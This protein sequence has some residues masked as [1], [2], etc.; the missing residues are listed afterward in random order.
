MIYKN[1]EFYNVEEIFE[2]P[3]GLQLS[4]IPES[5]RV[6]LNENAKTRALMPA[7]CEL[8]FNLKSEKAKIVMKASNE[9]IP[10]SGICE[11]YFGDFFEKWSYISENPTLIEIQYPQ[12][13]EKLREIKKE[14]NLKFDPQVIRILLPH[15]VDL[16]ILE[17]DGEFE[18]PEK[19]QVPDKKFLAYGSSITHGGFSIV[20]S[21]TYVAKTAYI[22]GI[23][24][25]NLGFG[26]GAHLEKEIADYIA[27]RKDWDFATF[28][29]GINMV[30]S[31]EVEEFKKRVDYFIEKIVKE[32]QE[33]YLFFIDMFP[34]YMDFDN[35]EK[36]KKFR[37]IVRNKVKEI[38]KENVIHISG[39]DM[40]K[41]I[42]G[43]MID[44]IHPCS[45]GFEE[46]GY[47]LASFLS[48]IFNW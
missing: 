39:L 10:R 19:Q 36:Q 4:R 24:A 31:F 5:V 43:L 11:I 9:I 8:R 18:L 35:Q 30:G 42:R 27:E 32:N 6:K 13:L 20:P 14:K 37:E 45:Q 26:G 28:E 3:D 7:G 22:L 34:F 17:I 29:L 2:K 15:L 1:I 21:Y 44:R 12:N 16:R 41:D 40:L 47:N 38:N 23:D 46:I 48:R 33:K 25:L